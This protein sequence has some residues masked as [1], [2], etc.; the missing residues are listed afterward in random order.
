MSPSDKTSTVVTYIAQGEKKA[1]KQEED[2]E[3]S[4]QREKAFTLLTF[5]KMTKGKTSLQEEG[6]GKPNQNS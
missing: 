2:K 3:M 4:W 6:E 5:R 1:P